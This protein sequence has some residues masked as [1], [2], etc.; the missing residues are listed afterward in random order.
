MVLGI[1]PLFV[2]DK[3]GNIFLINIGHHGTVTQVALALP[4]LVG[5]DVTGKGIAAL[6]TAG[7]G[8]LEAL[9]CATICLDFRH[10][11]FS[12]V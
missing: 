11:F 1:C 3:S 10:G 8:F 12:F 4:G 7:A 9:G 2:R 5:Q 6:D